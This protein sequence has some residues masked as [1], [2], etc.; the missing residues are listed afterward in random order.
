M[1]K[2]IGMEAEAA[3]LIT[4]THTHA[5]TLSGCVLVVL[6]E[7]GQAEVGDLAHQVVSNEDVSCSQVTMDVIHPLDVCHASC[8]LKST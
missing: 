1:Y 6:N 8:N 7:P 2:N 5:V 3:L 4:H